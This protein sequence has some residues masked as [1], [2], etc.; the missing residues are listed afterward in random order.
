[1]SEFLAFSDHLPLTTGHSLAFGFITP[2][3]FIAGGLLASIPIIIHILNRRRF[4]IVDWA[5]MD[6]LLK[7]LR[8]N[9][10]RIRFEQWLLLAVRCLVLA[11]LGL[12]LARP[13]GCEQ[14]TLATIAA[15]RSGL[16]V[17]V[18]DNSYSM[19][20]EAD[21]PDAKTHL[22]QAKLLAKQLIDRLS[23]GGESVAIITAATPS[24]AIIAR[25]S[26]DLDGAK[27]AI[28]RIQQSNTGTDL[29]GALQKALEIGRS[30]V[31][32]PARWLYLFTDSTRSA[33]DTP[34]SDALA[35]VAKDLGKVF[36]DQNSP[37]T[38]RITHFNLAKAG[39][40]NHAVIA[41][42]PG[43]NLVRSQFSNDFQTTIRG[44]GSENEAVIQWK[45]DDS[46]LPG[47][48]QIKPAIDTPA[49]TQSQV[50]IGKGGLHVVSVTLNGDN[51]LKV[52]DTR[53]R[54]VDVASELKVLV[55][56]GERG[57]GPLAGSGAFLQ[58]A[59]A[60]PSEGGAHILN[61]QQRTNS[62]VL[63]E[64]I[65]DLELSNKV[66]GEYRAVLMA[67]VPQFT[68]QQADQLR[69]FVEQGGTLMLFMGEPVNAEAY[70][71]ILRPR[72]LIPGQLT[73]RMSVAGN[74]PPYH[75]DF[76]PEGSLHSLLRIFQKRENTGLNTAQIFTYMRM[77]LPPE[78][79]A[80]VVLDYLPDSQGR[81]DP[82]ITLH[83]LGDGRVVFYST[84]ANWEWN[85]FVAKPS[86]VALMH[87]ILSG[88]ITSSDRWMNRTV[89]EPIEVPPT[90]QLS[91]N[92]TLKDPLRGDVI[93][94][95]VQTSEGRGVYRTAPIARP[96]IYTLE[97]GNRTYPIAVNVPDDEADIRPLD[98]PALKKAMG[99]IEVTLLDDQLPPPE[100]AQLAAQDF[101]W[102][103]MAIVLA[104][105]AME[106]FLAMRFGHYR[107]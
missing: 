82:A 62:Y 10:R 92:P 70:N 32:Q 88:S 86:F 80:Q 34:Q 44:Y 104:L 46:S 38:S 67:G 14:S 96:G 59:L 2:A 87:E 25:P 20:Y 98:G 4:K 48:G 79:N 33:W 29:L 35:A 11:I 31:S 93:L 58:L 105:V 54:V 37:Q 77:E 13:T 21:R 18:I 52:D 76:N 12:A 45:L 61:N 69:V 102:S 65:S 75:F 8:K 22:D 91:D 15:Q 7:A 16:H 26:Y 5:A 3:F 47:A 101:G 23:S 68:A 39:Q 6:F 78:T 90:I 43:A 30:E 100:Q 64:V 56:E 74:Q 27:G 55:V 19:S 66:L 83:D 60:P 1:M 40:W 95:Q 73:R 42:N 57:I 103:V 53:W 107:R 97:T 89:G 106:C 84:S 72:N 81:R 71:Q 24:S 50:Q 85:S 28:D 51:R 49:Q 9:R 99:D 63:P 36:A 94:E 17:L 41:I